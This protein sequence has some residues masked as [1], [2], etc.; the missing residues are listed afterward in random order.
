[1]TEYFLF[2]SSPFDEKYCV[3]GHFDAGGP[4][5]FYWGEGVQVFA[6]LG[7]LAKIHQKQNKILKKTSK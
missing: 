7:V 2:G 6:F 4:Y 5:E 1:M 3:W